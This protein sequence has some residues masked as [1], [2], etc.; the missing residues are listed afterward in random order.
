MINA[1]HAHEM[2]RETTIVENDVSKVNKVGVFF[3]TR[4]SMRCK[5][6][7]KA[8]S[9]DHSISTSS[10]YVWLDA[11]YRPTYEKPL[12]GS[13]FRVPF[14]ASF[15]VRC[16]RH[17]CSQREESLSKRPSKSLLFKCKKTGSK[18]SL[19]MLSTILSLR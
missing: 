8:F 16:C 4:P 17:L 9:M 6:R 14:V 12:C 11:G 5:I 18:R 15:P 7:A 2:N 1:L 3:K 19:I 13:P 10:Q